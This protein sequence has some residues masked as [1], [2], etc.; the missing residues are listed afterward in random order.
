MVEYFRADNPPRYFDGFT[1]SQTVS[2]LGICI[3][4]G[5]M[6]YAIKVNQ[7][8]FEADTKEESKKGEENGKKTESQASE[9]T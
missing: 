4:L 5:V 8:P 6:F 2:I 1:I 7:P 3:G 9:T